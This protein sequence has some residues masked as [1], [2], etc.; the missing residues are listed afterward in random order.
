MVDSGWWMGTRIRSKSLILT[1]D[2]DKQQFQRG[3]ALA[4]HAR[5]V[6]ALSEMEHKTA[7]LFELAILQKRVEATGIECKMAI[8]FLESDQSA[9]WFKSIRKEYSHEKD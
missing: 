5:N 6:V 9:G 8:H 7:K 2:C 1:F 3:V 4:N